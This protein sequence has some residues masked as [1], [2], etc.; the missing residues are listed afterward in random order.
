MTKMYDNLTLPEMAEQILENLNQANDHLTQADQKVINAA[1]I[2]V[3]AKQ[4]V[5]QGRAG[6]IGWYDWALEHTGLRETRLK[7]LY[8]IGIADDP[9]TELHR[10]R[11]LGK[12]RNKTL[13]DK[14]KAEAP[15]SRD[16]DDPLSETE[17]KA[18]TAPALE[19][20][21]DEIRCS[22]STI[23]PQSPPEG[24][25]ATAPGTASAKPLSAEYK[26][27]AELIRKFTAWA[28]KADFN[29]LRNEVTRIVDGIP[30]DFDR[31]PARREGQIDMSDAD[32]SS[33]S[34]KRKETVN[35]AVADAVSATLA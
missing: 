25:I 33:V 34:A 14:K 16:G 24:D 18:G 32:A 13:R 5:D 1:M 4:H 9:L 27:R 21:N 17:P 30:Y 11:G 10:Q 12:T 28:E 29:T 20:D 15:P 26:E 2:V 22:G 6:D 23:E 7:E 19:T 8:S 3:A 35:K 31:R